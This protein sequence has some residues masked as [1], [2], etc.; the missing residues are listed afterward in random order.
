MRRHADVQP[1]FTPP[2]K[3]PRGHPTM[4]RATLSLAAIPLSALLLAGCAQ[5]AESGDDKEIA[6][7]GGPVQNRL[8]IVT[9]GT[10]PAG[11]L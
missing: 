9:G 1:T 8:S 4:R 6:I 2:E 5:P 11:E 10:T 3:H 7:G